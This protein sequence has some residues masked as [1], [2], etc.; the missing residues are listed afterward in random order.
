MSN[1]YY[2]YVFRY[3]CIL[4]QLVWFI[5]LNIVHDILDIKQGF[6]EI[7]VMCDLYEKYNEI[8]GLCKV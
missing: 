5:Y 2:K 6:S 7:E 3:K 4:F 1:Y 8:L